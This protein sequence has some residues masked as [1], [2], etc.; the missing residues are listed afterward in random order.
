MFTR[1]VQQKR[2]L[3]LAARCDSDCQVLPRGSSD[4]D[5]SSVMPGSFK[6]VLAVSNFEDLKP[7]KTEKNKVIFYSFFIKR[8]CVRKHS[9]LNCRFSLA[10]KKFH[11]DVAPETART[12]LNARKFKNGMI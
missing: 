4:N 9:N 8:R 10:T 3:I 1:L 5:K 7:L 6:M 2:L 12:D 11:G